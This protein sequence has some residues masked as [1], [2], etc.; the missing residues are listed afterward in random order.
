MRMIQTTPGGGALSGLGTQSLRNF[1]RSNRRR[2]AISGGLARVGNALSGEFAGLAQQ[3][4]DVPTAAGRR[5]VMARCA[6]RALNSRSTI[7]QLNTLKAR[8]IQSAFAYLGMA[9]PPGYAGAGLAAIVLLALAALTGVNVPD[10]GALASIELELLKLSPEAVEALGA[11]LAPVVVDAEIVVETVEGASFLS[12]VIA[13]LVGVATAIAT[14]PP[15]MLIGVV[16]FVGVI[17]V[18]AVRHLMGG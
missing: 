18:I 14:L 16:V 4:V 5:A 17:G 12:E 15:A 3:L 13:A 7:A 1:A 9:R 2:P 11:N 10:I 6:A 8:D